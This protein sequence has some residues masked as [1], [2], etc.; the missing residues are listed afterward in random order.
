MYLN[1]GISQMEFGIVPDNLLKERFNT[2]KFFNFQSFQGLFP[3][4]D[5]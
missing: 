1:A 3:K 5:F 2:F 4:F